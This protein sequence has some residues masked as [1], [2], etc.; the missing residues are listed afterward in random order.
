MSKIDREKQI[1]EG[2]SNSEV[3]NKSKRDFIVMGATAVACIGAATAIVPFVRSLSPDAGELALG[4][5]EVD[6]SKM[7]VGDTITVMWRGTPVFIRKRTPEEIKE[8]E[9]VDLNQLRDPQSDDDR[10]LSGKPEWLV[11][12]AV[13]THLGCVPLSGKGDYGGWFCP[14]HGSHYDTS[15]RIRKGPAPLN[16]PVPQYTFINETT[17]LIG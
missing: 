7:N 1:D 6:V 17:I 16:L 13:C 5:T 14:C 11:V 12:I 2:N 15:G 8:A 4:S 10:I 9:D 3:P